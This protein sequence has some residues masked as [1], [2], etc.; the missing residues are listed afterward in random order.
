LTILLKGYAHKVNFI[1]HDSRLLSDTDPRQIAELFK[2]LNDY[3]KVS[4]K[5][6]NLTLNQNQLDEV[7]KY[8][9]EEEYK[10]IITDNICL[11]LKDE[12]PEDKLLG[13]QVN[14]EYNN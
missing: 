10:S 2:I 9:T 5:Q 14:M 8:L 7:K 4:G 6:Y 12:T 13:I 11:E 1:F 3:I